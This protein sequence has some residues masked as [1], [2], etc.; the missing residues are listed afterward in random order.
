MRLNK[1]EIGAVARQI[2]AAGQ[3]A[4]KKRKEELR[5]SLRDRAEKQMNIFTTLDPIIREELMGRNYDIDHFLN[6]LVNEKV[7]NGYLPKH[8]DFND[9]QDEILLCL[10]EC[11]TIDDIKAR[12]D[13]YEAD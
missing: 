10:K 5:E 1:S 3:E 11:K 9:L 2:L 6:P 4:N 7:S 12:I 8:K 13:P